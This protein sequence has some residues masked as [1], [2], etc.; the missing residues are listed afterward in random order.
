MSM[1]AVHKNMFGSISQLNQWLKGLL[2]STIACFCSARST[3][4]CSNHIRR[5]KR[6]LLIVSRRSPKGCHEHTD[7]ITLARMVLAVAARRVSVVVPCFR[8][9]HFLDDAISS[10]LR[11]THT[12]VEI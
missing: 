3:R 6:T 10:V 11:Q 1:V 2:Q 7:A 4:F 9:S 8:Q 12:N 5:P